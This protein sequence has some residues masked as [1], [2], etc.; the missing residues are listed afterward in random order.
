LLE[1]LRRLEL[2]E[3]YLERHSPVTKERGIFY[4]GGTSLSRPEVVRHRSRMESNYSKPSA[5]EL[6]MLLP[7]PP[8]KPFHK[9]EQ[10]KLLMDKLEDRLGTRSHV[11]HLCV[12]GA[13]FGVVPL[14]IDEMFPLSHFEGALAD[15]ESMRYVISQ[16]EDYVK[17]QGYGGV[18]LHRDEGWNELHRACERACRELKMPFFTT[19][20]MAE[21]WSEE[22][23]EELLK[24]AEEA[25]RGRRA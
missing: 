6:L 23:L 16:V 22:A 4:F 24:L 17:R 3:S 5:A 25:S 2:Y 19:S 18:V 15:E 7:F 10:L 11:F 14:E 8:T 21:P 1:A 13:P 20:G 9:S 12:Y